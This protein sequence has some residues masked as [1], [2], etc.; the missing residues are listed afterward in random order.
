[1]QGGKALAHYFNDSRK[2]AERLRAILI[3]DL[4]V[5]ASEPRELLEFASGYGAVTRHLLKVL[6]AF[7][8]TSCDI[9]PQ[10]NAFI[11]RELKVKTI[12][13]SALPRDFAP[14]RDFM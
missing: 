14:G 6:P 13:S 2:S 10:A 12:A 5:N 7:K 9:H 3:H 1:M 4:Q 11:E 8:L